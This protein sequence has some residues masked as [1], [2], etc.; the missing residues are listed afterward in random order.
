MHDQ[1]T[2]T[3]DLMRHGEPEGGIQLRGWKDD[4]LS[5]TGWQQ[6]REAVGE[7][8]HWQ[9]VVTSPMARCQ[10]LACEVAE[11]LGVELIVEERLKE[12]GFGDWEGCDPTKLYQ[13][14]PDRL[15]AFWSDPVANPPPNGESMIRFQA[16]VESAW[17]DMQIHHSGKQVL[18]VAHGGVNRI[19]LSHV[20]GM[21]LTHLFRLD[22]PFAG[23]SRI[24][25]DHGIPRLVSHCG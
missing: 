10:E 7:Q 17:Q 6:M 18:L 13:Q 25:V 9:R 23:M 15:I 19:I 2:T 16:R 14:D 8:A 22:I 11:R 1:Q 12:I 24:C 20:L 21:P 4:P 3:V 5:A